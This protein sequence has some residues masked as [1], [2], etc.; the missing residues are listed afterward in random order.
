MLTGIDVGHVI[1]QG[2]IHD[3]VVDVA[4]WVRINLRLDEWDTLDAA[5]FAAYDQV[6]DAYVAR[7]IDVYALIND[8]AVSSTLDHN[9][10]AWIAQ[11]VT[12]ATAI[13]DHFK[14]RV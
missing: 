8:E 1:D 13:V 2:V 4:P 11:Y 9:S 5:W 10:D 6:I 12:N 7:G 3:E 14:N